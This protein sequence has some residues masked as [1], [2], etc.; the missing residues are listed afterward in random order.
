M[1]AVPA[2]SCVDIAVQVVPHHTELV[3]AALLTA[4]Q[5]VKPERPR[6]ADITVRASDTWGA[7][8]PAGD[9]LT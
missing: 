4:N 7:D 9:R 5:R 8:T 3:T 6:Q 1:F 2:L